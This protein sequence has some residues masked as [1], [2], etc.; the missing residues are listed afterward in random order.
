MD[1][2]P[3]LTEDQWQKILSRLVVYTQRKF[4]RLGWKNKDGYRAPGGQGPEDIASEV[5]VK[6]IE[7]IRVY[8]A[9][10]CPDFQQFLRSCVD[11]DI[12]NLINSFEFKNKK[13]MPHVVTDKGETIE[14]DI[15]NKDAVNPLQICIEKEQI[16]L[17]KNLVQKVE[18]VLEKYFSE[19]KIV[20][21]IYECYEADIFKRSELAE[22]LEV[23]VKE[24]DNAQ[25]RL[26]REMD[27][28]FQ[29]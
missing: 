26:R 18:S 6:T 17:E 3:A 13:A 24:I 2:V 25:K 4:F 8:D 12:S 27:K 11:S 1:G 10:K 20:I 5:I 22:F 21:G 23:D 29:K 19:D 7:K 15:E 16:G 14:M 28:H 9:K